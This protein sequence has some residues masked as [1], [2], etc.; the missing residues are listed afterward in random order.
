MS[1]FLVPGP[2]HTPRPALPGVPILC[3]TSVKAAGLR[4]CVGSPLSMVQGTP[5]TRS[6][7]SFAVLVAMPERPPGRLEI[8]PLM[9]FGV[10]DEPELIVIIVAYSQAPRAARISSFD[11]FKVGR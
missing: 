6:G 5:G 9:I 7:R 1:K 2:R 11:L 8:L 3:P 10:S 4:I